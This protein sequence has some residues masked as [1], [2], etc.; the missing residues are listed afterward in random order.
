MQANFFLTRRTCIYIHFKRAYVSYDAQDY[1]LAVSAFIANFP[2]LHMNSHEHTKI[3]KMNL[4][5]Y[6]KSH[7]SIK[8]HKIKLSPIPCEKATRYL[9]IFYIPMSLI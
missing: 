8:I 1:V 9:K 4:H 6:L 2:V 3:M 7:I 5:F